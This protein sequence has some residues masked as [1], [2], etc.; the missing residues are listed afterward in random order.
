LLAALITA[1]AALVGVLY[2]QIATTNNAREG[3]AAQ[4]QLEEERAREA[5]LQTYFDDMGQMLLNEDAPLSEAA[6]GAQQVR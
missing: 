2:T 6:L 4:Q 5:E 1:I 3:L